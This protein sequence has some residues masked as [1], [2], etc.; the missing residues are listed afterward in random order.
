[1]STPY[2]LNMSLWHTAC[3]ALSVPGLLWARERLPAEWPVGMA[4]RQGHPG[5]LA[6][7]QPHSGFPLC[8]SGLTCS[9]ALL[10]PQGGVLLP[11][12]RALQPTQVT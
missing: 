8:S 7:L 5:F 11:S 10:R 9:W 6:L 2:N 1:M 12:P 3:S 4:V